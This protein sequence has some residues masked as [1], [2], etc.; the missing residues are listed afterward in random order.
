MAYLI[1][2][3]VFI[4]FLTARLPE[5]VSGWLEG[6]AISG[7]ACTSVVVYHE[8]LAGASTIKAGKAIDKITAPLDIIPVDKK[9]AAE[10]AS[11][12]RVWRNKG[13]TLGM[14]DTLIGATAKLRDLVVLTCNIK[15]F[16][17]VFAVDPYSVTEDAF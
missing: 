2:T 9:I 7:Y 5:E 4:D 1:D 12:R 10:A 16:P 13:K 11:I 8:L 17:D 3:C 14:A 15:D 6:L